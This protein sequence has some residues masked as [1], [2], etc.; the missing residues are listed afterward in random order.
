M[1]P[2]T[3][4]AEDDPPVPTLTNSTRSS[5]ITTFDFLRP[6]EIH[7]PDNL[8][9]FSSFIEQGFRNEKL[10]IDFFLPIRSVVLPDSSN[11]DENG[12][13]SVTLAAFK[14]KEAQMLVPD[15]IA[16]KNYCAEIA[17]ALCDSMRDYFHYHYKLI[18]PKKD[19]FA[20][21]IDLDFGQMPGDLYGIMKRDPYLVC[22][23]YFS[24]EGSQEAFR[25]LFQEFVEDRNRY[26][27]G[28]IA[29]LSNANAIGLVTYDRSIKKRRYFYLSK[30]VF[31]SYVSAY[32]HLKAA[33]NAL[34][35]KRKAFL[36][37]KKGV[38]KKEVTSNPVIIKAKVFPK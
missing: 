1:T 11:T 5:S 6:T 28:K 19:A 34:G 9:S 4:N 25:K 15:Y 14:F 10:D 3:N 21:S 8:V 27:H 30:E 35:A 36:D 29:Y 16:M 17:E 24:E 2:Q 18:I 37:N 22:E 13:S 20:R 12:V 23:K 31:Q 33:L 26:V 32:M 38:P 7:I